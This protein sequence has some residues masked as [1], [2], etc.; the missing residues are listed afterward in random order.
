[1]N[2]EGG[3]KLEP[4]VA[5]QVGLAEQQEGLTINLL[6]HSKEEPRAAFTHTCKLLMMTTYNTGVVTRSGQCSHREAMKSVVTVQLLHGLRTGVATWMPCSPSLCSR[7][8]LGGSV[9]MKLLKRSPK[10]PVTGNYQ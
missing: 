10:I 9:E 6:H 1:M 5:H 3:T 2:L 7:H 4:E 8:R